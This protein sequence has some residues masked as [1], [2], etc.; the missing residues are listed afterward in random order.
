M[1][2]AFKL[3][4]SSHTQEVKPILHPGFICNANRN[5]RI[6]K[7]CNMYNPDPKRFGYCTNKY[8]TGYR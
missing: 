3:N 7:F 5:L 6:I 2:H 1:K 4:I 8:A